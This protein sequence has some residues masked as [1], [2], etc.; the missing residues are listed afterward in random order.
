MSQRNVYQYDESHMYNLR[1]GED[2]R[3]L[4]NRH[5][6]ELKFKNT[7]VLYNLVKV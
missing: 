3:G 7:W 2:C 1:G 5:N 6:T 4:Y